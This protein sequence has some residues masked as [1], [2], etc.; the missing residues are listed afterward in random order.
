MNK[1]EKRKRTTEEEKNDT[2]DKIITISSYELRARGLTD[3][4]E[5]RLIAE[6]KVG[7]INIAVDFSIHIL[8][9]ALVR[10]ENGFFRFAALKKHITD[11]ESIDEF[12]M[13]HLSRYGIKFMYEPGKEIENLSPHEK[14]QLL[15]GAILP[16]VRNHIDL[17]LPKIV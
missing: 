6:Q 8:R 5:N 4:E 13:N 17:S 10:A 12:V 7:E 1:T 2:F 15:I 11:L 3:R 14:L 16:E 9:K